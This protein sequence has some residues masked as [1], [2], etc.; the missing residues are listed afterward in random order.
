MVVWNNK[1]TMLVC[2]IILMNLILGLL[3][4]FCFKNGFLVNNVLE[5]G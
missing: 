4:K 2:I 5:S 3:F 1:V